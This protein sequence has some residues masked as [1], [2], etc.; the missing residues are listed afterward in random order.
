M[1]P[2][3]SFLSGAA[4]LVYEVLWARRLALLFG[5]T[6]L[7]QTLTLAVF[8]GGLAAGAAALGPAADRAPAPL[9]FYAKLEWLAAL[10]GLL[11]PALLGLP[12][13]TAR[14]LALPL[15]LAQ[16]LVLGGTLPALC[17]AAGGEALASVG[18]LYALNSAGAAVGCL[19]AGFALIPRLGL[20]FSY[21]AAAALNAGIGAAAWAM[22]SDGAPSRLHREDSAYAGHLPGSLVL[23]VVL[24]SGCAA[25]TCE[26]AWTRLLAL[27]LGSSTYSFCEML[28]ALIAGLAVGSGVAASAGLRRRQPARW[29]GWAELGAGASLLLLL[30]VY[31]RLGLYFACLRP[32]FGASAASFYAYEAAKFAL[33]FCALLIPTACLGATLPLAARLAAEDGRE[34]GAVVG[35][36]LAAN[37]AG[38]VLGAFA[39]LWLLPA[40]GVEGLLRAST[41]V[42]LACGAAALWFA[43]AASP[44]RRAAWAA[45]GLLLWLGAR[46][47]LPRWDLRL[48]CQGTYRAQRVP[49]TLAELERMLKTPRLA[50][51]REDREASVATLVYPDGEVSLRVDGKADASTGAD[52]RTQIE[53]GELPLLL[54]P[55]AKSAL[56][57]GWG[58]G[59]TAGSMLRHP[60]ERLDAVE[61]L[62]GVVGASRLFAGVNGAP[63]DDPRLALSV[64]DAKTFLARPGPA[65]DVIV[66]EPSNPWMAGVGD[67]FSRQFYDRA[68][69]R[70][71]P[72]GL[73]VQWFHLYEMDDALLAL[74]LRTFRSRFPH[75]A[76]WSVLGSDIMLV[77]SRRPLAPDFA[78][79]QREWE[80][81]AVRADLERLGMSFPATLLGEQAAGE[82][83][84]GALAGAGTLADELRPVLEYEAP[85]ALFRESRAVSFYAQDDRADERRRRGLLLRRY[86][87]ERGRPLASLEFADRFLDAVDAPR[88]RPRLLE[89]VAE[90]RGRYPGDP[91]LARARKLLEQGAGR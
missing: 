86:L 11:A 54:R 4:G 30:P 68:A 78:A 91:R 52:M 37:T 47:A 77:G 10:A 2:A 27:V 39:G 36:V 82:G 89:L 79:F 43:S 55:R 76:A 31:G 40:L 67:L 41:T 21:T 81:P 6:A 62:P 29:L 53:L 8:L 74:V 5:S 72:D 32:H 50:F 28:A 64:E 17:R 42:F 9:R 85:K 19:A 88:E 60:L 80:R 75:V 45:A 66:S 1:L 70:L 69:A 61:L 71:A 44:R 13:G 35:A 90:W 65:Y 63:W 48:L 25:L 18:R 12:F 38:N 49:D 56:V 33:C 26:I 51:Y 20:S 24:L 16:A 15:L 59:V 23:A 83:T 22:R 3:L 46:A 57:V 34:R 7:A 14:W 84:V 58:S 87:D 73:M